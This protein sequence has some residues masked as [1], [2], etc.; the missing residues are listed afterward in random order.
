MQRIATIA[1]MYVDGRANWLE[2]ANVNLRAIPNAFNAM[3]DIAPV[4]AQI[5]R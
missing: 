5:E 2:P 4:A 3:T 1:N